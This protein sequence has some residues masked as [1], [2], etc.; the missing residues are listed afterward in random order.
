MACLASC[1]RIG[2][3]VAEQ[4][5]SA[6]A[7]VNFCDSNWSQIQ[8]LCGPSSDMIAENRSHISLIVTV[9]FRVL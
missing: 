7:D 1:K 5:C 9:F 2:L 4:F 6:K 8:E 3:F